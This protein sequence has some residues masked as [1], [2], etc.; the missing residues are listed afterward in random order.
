MERK[1]NLEELKKLAVEI[2]EEIPISKT[3]FW[4]AVAQHFFTDCGTYPIPNENGGFDVG[5]LEE[6]SPAYDMWKK[7]IKERINAATRAS[8][9]Y[10]MVTKPW[11]LLFV[12]FAEPFL[13]EEEFTDFFKDAYI[14]MEYPNSD[15]NFPVDELVSYFE[16]CDPNL[17]MSEN[18]LEVFNGLPDEVTIYRGVTSNNLDGV[19]A[20]SWSLSPEKAEWFATRFSSIKGRVYSATIS[21]ND[22]FAYFGLRGEQEVIVNPDYL[23]NIEV[24]KDFIE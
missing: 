11:S 23:E 8:S 24:Y 13:S 16:E 1:T 20:L 6:G 3:Q 10:T 9:I 7:D 22:I 17:L 2:V 21:K 14:K 15:P 12:K 5:F 19:E 18:E 4:P